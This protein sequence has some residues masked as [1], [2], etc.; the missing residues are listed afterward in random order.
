MARSAGYNRKQITELLKIV[1]EHRDNIERA[2]NEH[3]D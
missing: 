2:W 1:R 3:F